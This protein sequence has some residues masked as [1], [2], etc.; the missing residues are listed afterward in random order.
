MIFTEIFKNGSLIY[1]N[2]RAA[3][4]LY[5]RYF[6]AT[7]GRITCIPAIILGT[8]KLPCLG[9]YLT[10]SFSSFSMSFSMVFLM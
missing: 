6:S 9:F 2:G 4:R 8:C 5:K 10:V 1:Q 7:H 3:N